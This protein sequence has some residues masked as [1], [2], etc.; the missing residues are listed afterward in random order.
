MAT[1]LMPG[2]QH[3]SNFNKPRLSRHTLLVPNKPSISSR[4]SSDIFSHA[5]LGIATWYPFKYNFDLIHSF[6]EVPI[7]SKPWVGTFEC[8][9]PRTIG[10]NQDF[11]RNLVRRLLIRDNCIKIIALSN[12]AVERAKF[13]NKGWE[14]L[15]EMLKKLEVVHPSVP[16]RAK[17]PKRLSPK[18]VQ[19]TFCGR[20]FAQKGGIV[21]LRV[22]Q[23]A[24]KLKFPLKVNIISSLDAG[25]TDVSDR[26]RYQPDLELLDLPNVVFHKELPNSKVLDLFASSDFTFLPT[27]HD[28]YGYSVIEGFSVG[29][30]AIVTAT[31]ALPEIVRHGENGYLLNVEVDELNEIKWLGTKS[32]IWNR[33]YKGLLYTDEYWEQQNKT[34]NDLAQQTIEVLEKVSIDPEHYEQLSQKSIDQVNNCHNIKTI[35]NYFDCLYDEILGTSN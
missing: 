20:M 16:L 23:V 8:E 31:C 15:P 13:W 3:L 28:T 11:R 35:S 22:A 33:I 12:F 21:A 27:L 5:L 24:N 6:N 17:Q 10:K 25:W 14:L 29:T 4:L 34:Y 7:T 18:E 1:I 2:P 32:D 26:G 19:L 30:P 9:I